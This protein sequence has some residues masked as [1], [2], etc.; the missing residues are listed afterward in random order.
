VIEKLK[1]ILFEAINNQGFLEKFGFL[2]CNKT[3]EGD[4]I[5]P[6]WLDSNVP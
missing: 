3:L 4:S 6:P 1:E 2:H 5:S